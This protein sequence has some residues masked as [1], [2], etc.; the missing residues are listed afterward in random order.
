[1]LNPLGGEFTTVEEN[2]YRTCYNLSVVFFLTHSTESYFFSLGPKG[3]TTHGTDLTQ[4]YI[5]C[6]DLGVFDLFITL[7][8]LRT[9]LFWMIFKNA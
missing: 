6:F 7:A 9:Q 3:L 1:M 5:I 4:E 2:V 8:P